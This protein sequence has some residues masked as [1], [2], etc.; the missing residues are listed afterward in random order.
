MGMGM[1]AGMGLILFS[2]DK[3]LGKSGA[4]RELALLL[5]PKAGGVVCPGAYAEGRK[6]AVYWQDLARAGR[7]E[8]DLL[9][10]ESRAFVGAPGQPRLDE[11]EEG[12]LRYGKWEFNKLALAN[13]DGAC[14]RALMDPSARL[15]IVDEIGPL[16]LS[17]GLGYIKTLARLDIL[18]G[19]ASEEPSAG[20]RGLPGPRKAVI[21]ALRPDLAPLLARRWPGGALF[22]LTRDNRDTA[23]ASLAAL[24]SSWL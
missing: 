8:P 20:E 13:A 12:L 11:S 15:A 23:A 2:G 21:V 18:Y 10:R 6:S 4:L 19:V 24:I 3:G 5:G 17:F 7:E 14:L 16:E 22:E 1:G 9:A